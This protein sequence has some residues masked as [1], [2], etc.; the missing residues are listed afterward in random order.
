MRLKILIVDAL[1]N[2]VSTMADNLKVKCTQVLGVK[3]W[4]S[5]LVK[6]NPVKRKV[7][8]L[9]AIQLFTENDIDRLYHRVWNW[10][11]NRQVIVFNQVNKY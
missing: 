9:R 7:V 6:R 4:I 10:D 1:N 2:P 5:N 8:E 3:V 11:K